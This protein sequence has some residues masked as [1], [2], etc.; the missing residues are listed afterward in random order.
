MVYPPR[1]RASDDADATVPPVPATADGIV[2]T[3]QHLA[4]GSIPY[5]T[6]DR[7]FTIMN[8]M[9]TAVEYQL[10]PLGDVNGRS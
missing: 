6:S 4:E 9:I 3:V 10:L 8:G 7:V 1:C 5:A 2:V